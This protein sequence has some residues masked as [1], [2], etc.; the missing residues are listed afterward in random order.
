MGFVVGDV[1][2]PGP[3]AWRPPQKAALVTSL[4]QGATIIPSSRC[5]KLPL[6]CLQPPQ[7]DLVGSHPNPLSGQ[8]PDGPTAATAARNRGGQ[9]VVILS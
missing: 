8:T 6:L 1:A 5:L 4:A 3:F 2:P 9:S 7:S